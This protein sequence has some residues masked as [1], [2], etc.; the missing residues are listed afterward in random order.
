MSHRNTQQGL[1]WSCWLHDGCYST[2]TAQNNHFILTEPTLPIPEIP[3][4]EQAHQ[5]GMCAV[6]K[7]VPTE[8]QSPGTWGWLQ[9][10]KREPKVWHNQ[11]TS[12][13]AAWAQLLDNHLGPP[14]VCP[15][16]T[17]VCTGSGEK[18]LSF[19]GSPDSFKHVIWDQIMIN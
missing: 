10:P 5:G 12:W 7:H 19:G 15:K 17:Q 14:W 13:G 1:C 2:R 11:E 4:R 3:W 6:R 16:A 9:F 8:T 18:G